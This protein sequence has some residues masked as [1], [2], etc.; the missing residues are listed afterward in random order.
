MKKVIFW[1]LTVL[2]TILSFPFVVVGFVYDSVYEE[3][4]NGRRYHRKF[5][6]WMNKLY[7]SI[8]PKYYE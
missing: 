5:I 6:W 4:K 8:N 1:F 2:Y 7:K 3:F